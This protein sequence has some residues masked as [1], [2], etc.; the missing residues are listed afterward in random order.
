MK[1]NIQDIFIYAVTKYIY[2]YLQV[3]VLY[4]IYLIGK[5][6]SSDKN[7]SVHLFGMQHLLEG[8]NEDD[9]YFSCVRFQSTEST[10]ERVYP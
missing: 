8:H 1:Y 3:Q 2:T 5:V 4:D 6:L 9:M 10:G 7:W